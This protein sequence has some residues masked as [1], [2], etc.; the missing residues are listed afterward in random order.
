[1]LQFS[2]RSVA[3]DRQAAEGGATVKMY[4]LVRDI[5]YLARHRWAGELHVRFKRV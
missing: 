1:M 5:I 2:G 3:L 4:S